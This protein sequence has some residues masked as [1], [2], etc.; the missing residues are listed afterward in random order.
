MTLKKHLI[1][2]QSIVANNFKNCQNWS[3]WQTSINSVTLIII[4]TQYSYY[5]QKVKVVPIR[6]FLFVL[7]PIPGNVVSSDRLNSISPFIISVLGSQMS[8]L[9]K[10]IFQKKFKIA[11]NKKNR[12]LE[13]KFGSILRIIQFWGPVFRLFI[14]RIL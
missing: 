6:L 10:L 2:H 14:Y 1:K 7:V 5:C 12:F 9:I 4:S 3:H 13:I 11:A 8:L